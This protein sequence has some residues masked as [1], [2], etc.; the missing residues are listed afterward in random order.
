MRLIETHIVGGLF[1]TILDEIIESTR[2]RV[3]EE[4]RL[5]PIEEMKLD[6]SERRS[7]RESINQG[8]E[9][10]V[11]AEIK[12]MSPSSGD[13]RPDVDLVKVTG[14]MTRGGSVGISVLTEPDYFNGRLDFIPVVREATHLPVLR[15]DFIVD[16]Y[17]LYESAEAGADAALLITEVLGKSLPEFVK[18]SRELEIECLVEVSNEDQ[19]ELA[20]QC[21][22]DLIGINNRDLK[23]MKIDPSRTERLAKLIPDEVTVVSESGINE[24]ADVKRMLEDGADA[25]LVGTSIMKSKDIE[26]KVRRLT[27]VGES[28]G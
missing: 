12:R 17:Q 5:H 9:A 15:K 20:I 10:A 11:I 4:S 6:S 18:T 27:G 24:A 1:L 22:P 21:A 13:I 3:G 25:V 14:E 7:L 16:K 19:V 23:S 8:P 2:K 28:N 26:G